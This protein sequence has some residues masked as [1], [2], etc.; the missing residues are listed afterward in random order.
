MEV[1][2]VAGFE[3]DDGNRLHC[4]KHG[5]EPAESETVFQGAPRGAPDR[6]HSD[7]EARFLAIGRPREGRAAFV[8]FSM[9][10]N[11]IRPLS[12]RYMHAKEVANYD[13]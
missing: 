9:R 5:M 6:K 13:P 12:A 11:L 1:G 2:C 10:G 7:A 8:V 3:W 4:R